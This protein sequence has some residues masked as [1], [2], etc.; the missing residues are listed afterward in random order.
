VHH[1][2]DAHR[3]QVR[4]DHVVACIQRHTY[5]NTHYAR[6]DEGVDAIAFAEEHGWIPGDDLPVYRWDDVPK[7]VADFANNSL[8]SYFPLFAVN[9]PA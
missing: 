4:A 6:F 9:P 1:Q 5:V 3:P 7:L 8:R 2:L